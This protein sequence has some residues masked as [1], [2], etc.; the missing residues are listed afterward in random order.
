MTGSSPS[1]MRIAPAPMLDMRTIA[2]WLSVMLTASQFPA[3]QGGFLSDNIAI[4]A[5]S[6]TNSPVTAK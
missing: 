3:Q 1:C 6:S 4:G 2:V 5:L